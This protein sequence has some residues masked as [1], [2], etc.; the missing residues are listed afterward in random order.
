MLHFLYDQ[1]SRDLILMAAQIENKLLMER[2]GNI[3]V[4]VKSAEMIILLQYQTD[5]KKILKLRKGPS[6][7]YIINHASYRIIY[8][9]NQ[10]N[11]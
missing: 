9:D 3:H 6:Y 11:I 8:S 5:L 2:E 10:M 1:K 4:F 7:Y